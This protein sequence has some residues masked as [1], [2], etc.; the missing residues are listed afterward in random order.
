LIV[1]GVRTDNSAAPAVACYSSQGSSGSPDLT[2]IGS[3]LINSPSTDY[4][5]LFCKV[6]TGGETNL[7]ASFNHSN[8]G[9]T[10]SSSVIG[11]LGFSGFQGTPTLDPNTTSRGATSSATTSVGTGVVTTAAVPEVYVAFA[12]LSHVYSGSPDFVI[13]LSSGSVSTTAGTTQLLA[14]YYVSTGSLGNGGYAFA[15]PTGT[16][17][18]SIIGASFFDQQWTPPRRNPS[19]AVRQ[20]STYFSRVPWK[21]KGRLLVPGFAEKRLVVA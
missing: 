21:A 6:A 3:P 4:V 20:A 2:Q 17:N 13:V 16:G 10:T 15:W 9:T 12:A 14:G 18:A 8:Q 5:S 1:V 11:Y 19:M 7:Q